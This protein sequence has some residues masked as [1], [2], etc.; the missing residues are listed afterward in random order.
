MWNGFLDSLTV[1]LGFRPSFLQS[2]ALPPSTIG[3]PVCA[4]VCAVL[5]AQCDVGDAD[6]LGETTTWSEFD[7]RG[8]E[9]LSPPRHGKRS[10]ALSPARRPVLDGLRAGGGG[11]SG[12]AGAVMGSTAGSV[13]SVDSVDGGTHLRAG[14][15]RRRIVGGAALYATTNQIG[16]RWSGAAE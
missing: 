15:R 10:A 16:A 2:P 3:S 13:M 8:R 7:V 12:L 1:R 14:R 5:V 9:T 11:N 4:C 6:H